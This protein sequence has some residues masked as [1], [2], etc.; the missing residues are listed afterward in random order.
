MEVTYKKHINVDKKNRTEFLLI[1]WDYEDGGDYLAKI[2]CKEFGMSA[3]EKVDYIY[4]SIIKLHLDKITYE[5]LWHEDFGNMIYSTEQEE[6][7]VDTLEQRLK[8][9]LSILNEKLNSN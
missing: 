5:L 9:A 2:F 7:V 1:N 3:E 8:V 6:A 4:F